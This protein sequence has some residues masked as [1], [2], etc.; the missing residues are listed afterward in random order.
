MSDYKEI[1]AKQLLQSVSRRVPKIKPCIFLG[2]KNKP[3][4]IWIFKHKCKY[5]F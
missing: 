2:A 3:Q 5:I 4:D 1:F